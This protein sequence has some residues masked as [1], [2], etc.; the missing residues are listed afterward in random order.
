M[1][2]TTEIAWFPLAALLLLPTPG[3][4]TVGSVRAVCIAFATRKAS[5]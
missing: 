2:T 5:T 1:I 4:N 3:P